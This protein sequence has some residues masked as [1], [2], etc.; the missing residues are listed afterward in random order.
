MKQYCGNSPSR[1]RSRGETGN[2]ERLLPVTGRGLGTFK[3]YEGGGFSMSFG[4]LGTG[5]REGE[6]KINLQVSILDS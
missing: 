6:S 5:E 1:A 4:Q 3:S 2:G